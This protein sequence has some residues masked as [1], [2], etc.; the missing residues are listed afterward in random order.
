MTLEDTSLVHEASLISKTVLN[1]DQLC[2]SMSTQYGYHVF[3]QEAMKWCQ[4]LANGQWSW[5]KHNVSNVCPSFDAIQTDGSWNVHCLKQS[6][7]LCRTIYISI[8]QREC[9]D[10]SAEDLGSCHIA[11]YDPCQMDNV[12]ASDTVPIYIHVVYSPIWRRPVAYIP[13]SPNPELNRRLERWMMTANMRH[14]Q[15]TN[16]ISLQE[17]P[18]LSIPCYFVH[19]CHAMEVIVELREANSDELGSLLEYWMEL[20]EPLFEQITNASQI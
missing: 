15:A 6:G 3:Y 12:V 2:K 4:G 11:E 10:V 16:A 8:N 7:Y 19:P 1:N 18:Y 20:H 9:S 13:C 14:Q 5:Q 17:H